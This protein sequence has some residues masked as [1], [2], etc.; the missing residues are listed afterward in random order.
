MWIIARFA[1]ALKMVN[2][3]ETQQQQ[4][5]H[6][7]NDFPCGWI[8]LSTCASHQK[9]Q[10]PTTTTANETNTIYLWNWYMPFQVSFS[11]FFVLLSCFTQSECTTSYTCTQ[12]TMGLPISENIRF[13][14]VFPIRHL[15]DTHI[16]VVLLMVSSNE[17]R[18]INNAFIQSVN[19]AS[20]VSRHSNSTNGE[21]VWQ[22]GPQRRNGIYF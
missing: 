12:S 8:S 21:N 2:K 3:I 5:R 7:N 6:T 17:N 18:V 22:C 14:F 11:H 19:N 20:D 13:V 9:N 4:R 10:N 1:A 16:S 15:R